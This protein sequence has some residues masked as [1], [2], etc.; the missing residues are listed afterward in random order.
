ML[1]LIR[2]GCQW[3]L[4]PKDFPPFTTVQ[5][6]FYRWRDSEIWSQIL[7]LLVMDEREADGSTEL[8]ASQ[9]IARKPSLRLW[10]SFRWFSLSSSSEDWRE[11]HPPSEFRVMLLG[12]A[13]LF[14]VNSAKFTA[15]MF[16]MSCSAYFIQLCAERAV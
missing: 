14:S 15:F 5:N 13:W 7:C 11:I 16:L 2:S 8:A 12:R 6:H 4:L 1:Y 9:R 3:R 10:P